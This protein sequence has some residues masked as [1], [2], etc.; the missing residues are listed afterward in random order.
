MLC[1]AVDEVLD[2]E[3]NEMLRRP[4]RRLIGLVGE[5]EEGGDPAISIDEL[6]DDCSAVDEG[7]LD[8]RRSNSRL[9]RNGLKSYNRIL[10][11]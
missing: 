3:K 9:T 2:G 11:L 7:K 6:G 10:A 8:A 5:E 1:T 4:E